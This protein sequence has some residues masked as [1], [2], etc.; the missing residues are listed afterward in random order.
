[1]DLDSMKKEL[2]VTNSDAA[3]LTLCVQQHVRKMLQ[4]H[5]VDVAIVFQ[6]TMHTFIRIH[7]EEEFQLDKGAVGRAIR[8]RECVVNQSDEV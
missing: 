8:S 3:S 7:P 6:D 5:E 2:D 1:M 4:D